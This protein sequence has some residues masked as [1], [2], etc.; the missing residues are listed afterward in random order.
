[1]IK[2]VVE[3]YHAILSVAN[4]EAA[5][6][7]Y[8]T[9]LGFVHAFSWGTPPTMAGVNLGETQIFLQSGTPSPR[10]A[11]LYYVVD[12]ADRLYEFHR[13]NGVEILEE[14][15][16]REWD[17]RDYTVMDRDGYRITFGHRLS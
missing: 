5:V 15:G 12:D 8:S 9:R 7:F 10:A 2:V 1:M 6:E 14:P 3:Q 13:S 11:A 16:D 4:L 17:F